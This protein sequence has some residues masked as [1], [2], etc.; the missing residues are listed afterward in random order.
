MKSFFISL[1][2][3]VIIGAGGFALYEYVAEQTRGEGPSVRT[4]EAVRRDLSEI[5]NATGEVRPV[6]ESIVKSEISGRIA[7]IKVEAGDL[8]ERGQELLKLD[9]VVLE[10]RLREAERSLEAERLRYNQAKRNRDR[11]AEL[12]E[13]NFLGEREFLDEQTGYD[14]ALINTEIAQTR[15]EEIVEDIRKSNLTAPHSGMITL[16]N[17]TEGQVISGA[18]SVSDGT[19]LL[20]VAQLDNLYMEANVNE[21][22]ISKIEIG[23]E[24]S[25]TFDAHPDLEMVGHIRSISPSAIRE[26]NTRVFPIRIF[27]DGSD[28]RVRPGISATVAIT[29]ASSKQAL[30]VSLSSV[31]A[32]GR[33]R[34][35]FLYNGVEFERRPV[36]LGVGNL[37]Y[38]EVLS[39]LSEGDLVARNRPPETR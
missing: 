16:L 28:D 20:T 26:G 31:F 32:E 8:V 3:I 27:L 11:S 37:R 4:V 24:V 13:R 22:D 17:V 23:D 38:V 18:T 12:F 1:L 2:F 33:D 10:T 30:S 36:E 34:F 15:M 14:I 9:T 21:V 25:V 35:V 5:V 6:L 7:E 29:I 39:G 19:D